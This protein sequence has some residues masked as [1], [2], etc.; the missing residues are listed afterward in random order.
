MANER[1][2][3]QPRWVWTALAIS[4]VPSIA[5]LLFSLTVSGRTF[6]VMLLVAEAFTAL[7][8]FMRWAQ[9]ERIRIEDELGGTGEYPPGT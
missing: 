6:A 2:W 9:S 1:V 3:G 8:L 4:T 7:S 5:L